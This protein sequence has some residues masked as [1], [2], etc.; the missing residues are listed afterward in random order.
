M[1]TALQE[2]LGGFSYDLGQDLERSE[3]LEQVKKLVASSRRTPHDSFHRAHRTMRRNGG[4][5]VRNIRT[6]EAG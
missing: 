3:A 5:L 4:V 2:L 6:D 1:A